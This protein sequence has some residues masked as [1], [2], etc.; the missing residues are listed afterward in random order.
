M[1]PIVAVAASSLALT[2]LAN[3]TGEGAMLG[4]H[5]EVQNLGWSDGTVISLA[6]PAVGHGA[7]SVIVPHLPP[8]TAATPVLATP[9]ALWVGSHAVLLGAVEPYDPFLRPL[10]NPDMAHHRLA[11]AL[12]A[13]RLRA[14][15][16]SL[17][18]VA[19]GTLHTATRAAAMRLTAGPSEDLPRLLLGR[20]IGLTPAGD[21]FLLGILVAH[22]WW[23][24]QLQMGNALAAAVVRE[25]PDRTTRLSA[26]LLTAAAR[27]AADAH[28]HTLANALD[29]AAPLDRAIDALLSHGATSGADAL[30]GVAAVVGL[31]RV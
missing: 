22:R 3:T 28:W 2:A 23:P 12:P 25:A 15:H 19:S 11:A 29:G 27:G 1:P 31:N 24:P 16:G 17:L 4:V 14:P 30:A 9:E 6:L 8:A 20:G 26:A 21:D 18:T 13:A 7:L 10:A 5:S